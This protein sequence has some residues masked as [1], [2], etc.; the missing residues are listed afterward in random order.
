MTGP[1]GGMSQGERGEEYS[2]RGN[3][4]REASVVQRPQ[5]LTVTVDWCD[6]SS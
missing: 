4:I 2:R 3:S 6:C 5:C 1:L